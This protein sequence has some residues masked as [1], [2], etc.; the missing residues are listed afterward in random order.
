MAALCWRLTPLPI[1]NIPDL[2]RTLRQFLLEKPMPD[3][4][5]LEVQ[6][7]LIELGFDPGAPDGIRGEKT[8]R[9][10]ADFKRSIGMRPRPYLGPLTYKALFSTKPKS[11][12]A[13]AAQQ[14]RG[15]AWMVHANAVRGVHEVRN[16]SRLKRWLS[17][18]GPYDWR[19]VAW[20]G[21]FVRTVFKMWNP[22]IEIPKNPLG[23]R[24]WM[25]FGV[26]CK[27]QLGAVLVFWRGSRKGWKG[28][29]GFYVG[30]TAHHYLVLGG[31]QSNAV[32]VSKIAKTR[33]L[34]ARWPKGAK[35][36]GK[37]IVASGSGIAVTTNEA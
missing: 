13:Q 10:V 1:F 36:L 22:S 30:E 11:K 6:K 23:A 3:I 5:W 37:V 21:A 27:P 12:T 28:H 20:C 15:A 35:E 4:D 32:T 29:V 31:N 8:D 7:R 24:N 2:G 25:K 16:Y 33:L 17:G 9:A 26:A 19:K 14:S 34:G 18:S